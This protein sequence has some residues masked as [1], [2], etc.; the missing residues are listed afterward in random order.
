MSLPFNNSIQIS[1]SVININIVSLSYLFR[2]TYGPSPPNHERIKV[3]SEYINKIIA[4]IDKPIVIN[5]TGETVYSLQLTRGIIPLLKCSND[6]T[7]I[8]SVEDNGI[9]RDY[10]YKVDFNAMC[11]WYNFYQD[12]QTLNIDWKN[13]RIDKSILSL[14][15]RPNMSRANVTKFLLDNYKDKSIVSLGLNQVNNHLK[16]LIIKEM[17]PYELPIIIDKDINTLEQQ[18]SPPENIIYQCLLQI[19]NETLEHGNDYIFLS[20]KSFKVFAWHQLPIFVTVQGHVQKIRE[21]GFD[22]FDDIFDGHSYDEKR[23]SNTHKLKIFSTIKKFMDTYP[24]IEHQRDLRNKLWNRIETNNLH[25]AK[26]VAQ[27]R[28]IL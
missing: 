8:G 23:F 21:L 19:V 15:N 10:N 5:A 18:H 28:I 20:E 22:V 25:L 9:L 1:E 3:L 27:S 11:N 17:Y 24:T 26:L 12:L 13:I 16:S 14:A 6:I 4:G 7:I 2:K